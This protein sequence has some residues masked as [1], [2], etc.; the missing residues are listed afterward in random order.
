MKE[1]FLGVLKFP[2]TI[3]NFCLQTGGEPDARGP[4]VHSPKPCNII[5]MCILSISDFYL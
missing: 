4:E 3:L 5:R 1:S 2:T